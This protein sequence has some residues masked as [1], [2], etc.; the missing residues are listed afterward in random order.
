ME[1][2]KGDIGYGNNFLDMTLKAQCI[3]ERIDKVYFTI[4]QKKIFE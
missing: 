2:N 3:K 4:E 1:K